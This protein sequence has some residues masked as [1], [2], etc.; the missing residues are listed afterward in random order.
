MKRF[1]ALLVLA[2]CFPHQPRLRHATMAVEGAAIVTGVV[3]AAFAPKPQEYCNPGGGFFGVLGD[4]HDSS[5]PVGP[6][7]VG[8]IVAGLAGLV[9]T[10]ATADDPKP[11]EHVKLVP[12]VPVHEVRGLG[13]PPSLGA[14]EALATARSYAK[15]HALRLDD[16][17]LHGSEFDGYTRDWVFDWQPPQGDRVTI[18]VNESGQVAVA[19]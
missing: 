19:R 11:P 8:L 10:G 13:E 9:V 5:S 3:M 12:L 14:P 18:T 4:C 6:I 7:G 1:A 17:D 15:G 2:G 16:R